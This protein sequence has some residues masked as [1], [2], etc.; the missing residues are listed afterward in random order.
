MTSTRDKNSKE[1]YR[2]EQRGMQYIRKNLTFIN[3]PNGHAYKPAITE[4]FSA[5]R[6]P[7]DNLSYNPTDIESSLLGINS[8]NLVNYNLP[9]HPQFKQTPFLSF[10][11]Q[12]KLVMPKT[13][14]IPNSDRPTII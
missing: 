6:M 8:N 14:R 10:Y 9:V 12:P 3:C 13:V 11:E 1:N 4:S 2:L 5:S 7:A